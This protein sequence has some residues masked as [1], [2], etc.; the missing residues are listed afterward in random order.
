MPSESG[1][2]YAPPGYLLFVREGTLMAQAFD[3]R[4]RQVT[5]EPLPVAEGVGRV[6]G[7]A[8]TSYAAFSASATG[9]L[10]YGSAPHLSNQLL[11]IDRGGTV[12]GSVGAP[13]D[14]ADP[15]LSADGRRLAVCRDDPQTATP[16]IWIADLVRGNFSRFAFHPRWEV[17]PVWSPDGTRIAFGSDRTPPTQL[18]VKPTAGGAEERVLDTTYDAY[19][20]DWSPDGRFLIYSGGRASATRND[21]WMLPLDGERRPRP[22]LQ[23]PFHEAEG[24]LSPDGRVLAFSSDESGRPEVYVGRMPTLT[25]R[26]QVSTGGGRFPT[27][28]RDGK[29]LFYLAA[30]RK[31][32]AVGFATGSASEG[33]VPSALFQTRVPQADFPGF[34]S[35]YV[36]ATDGQRF[37][38]LT[39][40][41]TFHSPPVTIVLNWS[42]DL[43]R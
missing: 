34:H 27:W 40:P 28:R 14:Y 37:L 15:A 8:P 2:L 5:G 35:M 6:G 26:W 39:E 24:Q 12:R 3:A 36:P 25:E 21:I 30:D 7:G 17:Y 22:L 1:A 16:D 23:S 31:L 18:Y 41:E 9:V 29:E 19:P 32:M 38:V 43:T 4:A 10:A 11:W 13:G 42:A 33:S 20:T